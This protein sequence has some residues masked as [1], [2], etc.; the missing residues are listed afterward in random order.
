MTETGQP[1]PLVFDC[2]C[3]SHFALADRLDVLRALYVDHICHTTH[4][5]REE[6]RAGVDKHPALLDALNLDWLII[7]RLDSLQELACFAEWVQRLGSASRNLGEASVFSAAELLGAV[8]ISDDQEAVRVGRRYG[9]TVHGTLWL[10]SRACSDG[11][12]TEVNVINLIDALRHTGMRLPC[13]G[14]EY[15]TWARSHGLL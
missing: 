15:S 5:V 8:A 3:L 4:V 1:F 14:S 2:M 6:L 12:L 11:K 7:E 13:S 9:L 10:L